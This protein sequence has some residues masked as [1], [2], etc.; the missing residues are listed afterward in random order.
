[1]E[2]QETDKGLTVI[3]ASEGKYLYDG[4]TVI[5]HRVYLGQG[6]S[7][8]KYTEIDETQKASIEAELAAKQEATATGEAEGEAEGE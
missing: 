8:D 1:M 2:K 6:A 4:A 3:T 5:A 7:A